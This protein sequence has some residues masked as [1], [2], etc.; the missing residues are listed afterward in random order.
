[1]F[2]DVKLQLRSFLRRVAIGLWTILSAQKEIVLKLREQEAMINDVEDL[3]TQVR[4]VRTTDPTVDSIKMRIHAIKAD[5]KQDQAI[6]AA[7]LIYSRL[8]RLI[9]YEPDALLLRRLTTPS[10]CAAIL[11]DLDE[12]YPNSKIRQ[13]LQLVS[14][15]VSFIFERLR[16]ALDRQRTASK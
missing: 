12:M 10:D 14:I 11:R 3:L 13:R 5:I 8:W 6:M 9:V 15:N 2:N 7:G 4:G 1:M 16:N